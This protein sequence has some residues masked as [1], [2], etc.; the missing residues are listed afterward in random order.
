MSPRSGWPRSGQ[1]SPTPEVWKGGAA[2]QRAPELQE[3]LGQRAPGFWSPTGEH[4]L[5]IS[6]DPV[7]ASGTK[8][9]LDSPGTEVGVALG[10]AVPK[11]S[12]V[13]LGVNS[14]VAPSL[15]PYGVRSVPGIIW[16]VSPLHEN[17][18]KPE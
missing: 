15:F 16:R 11:V 14:Q 8:G 9:R 17:S 7:P 1:R 10:P 3:S 5:G 13:Q 18:F 6:K 12:K 2:P 4:F